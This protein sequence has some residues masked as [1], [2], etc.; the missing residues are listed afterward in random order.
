MTYSVYHTQHLR[1]SLEGDGVVQFPESQSIKGPLLTSGAVDAA[2]YLLNQGLDIAKLRSL[3]S[4]SKKFPDFFFHLLR[5][6][7]QNVTNQ[8]NTFK[9]CRTKET[10]KFIVQME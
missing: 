2:L 6:S 8:A 3:F 4:I 10:A 1:R 7:P 9:N 5:Q